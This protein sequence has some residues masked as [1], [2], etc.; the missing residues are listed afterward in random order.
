MLKQLVNSTLI[1]VFVSVC[2]GSASFAAYAEVYR[3]TD[4]AGKVVYS[5]SKPTANSTATK[6]GDKSSATVSFYSTESR[7]D[8]KPAHPASSLEHIASVSNNKTTTPSR[9]TNEQDCQDS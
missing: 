4:A 1:S 6:L 2:L 5:D 3:W 8:N 9:Q 7:A